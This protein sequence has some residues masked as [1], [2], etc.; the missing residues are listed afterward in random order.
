MNIEKI[1]NFIA[2]KMSVVG[3]RS[4]QCARIRSPLSKCSNCLD[5][6]PQQ[7]IK[8]SGKTLLLAD[9]CLDCGLCASVCPTGALSLKEPDN[10][11][12]LN[13]IE[14]AYDNDGVVNITC[15]RNSLADEGCVK[16]PCI[17]ALMPEML[18]VMRLYDFPIHIIY[19]E[20]ECRACA[21]HNGLDLFNSRLVLVDDI[22]N[23]FSFAAYELVQLGKA[24]LG[25]IKE[26]KPKHKQTDI[27]LDRRALFN[28]V[29]TGFRKMPEVVLQTY[30][31]TEKNK[32]P[33]KSAPQKVTNYTAI[34]RIEIL[35]RYVYEK[36]PLAEGEFNLLQQ[37]HLVDVCYFCNV[38]TILCPTGAIENNQK[39][40]ELILNAS[41]CTGCNLCVDVCYHKSLQ[42]KPVSLETV[43]IDTATKLATGHTNVCEECQET[44]TA[45]T[46]GTKCAKCQLYKRF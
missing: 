14:Q 30:V 39:S 35:K 21:V 7:R 42:L 41:R 45:S 4:Q 12:I 40:K 13:K 23:E 17:G 36:L 9:N 29:F 19:D 37:P 15:R 26:S 24:K 22:I 8:I 1:A 10:L 27:N 44:F 38:C 33:A 3:V 28:S 34:D 32:K 31:E 25:K 20:A 2:D 11:M 18:L 16:I 5:I 6:C 46:V 43:M